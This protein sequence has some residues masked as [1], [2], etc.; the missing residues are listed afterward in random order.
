MNGTEGANQDPQRR[1]TAGR[2]IREGTLRV[3]GLDRRHTKALRD[4]LAPR[5]G[6]HVTVLATVVYLG[7]PD[8]VGFVESV[9]DRLDA[10]WRSMDG[11]ALHARLAEVSGPRHRVVLLLRVRARIL[12]ALARRPEP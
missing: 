4:V 9:L 8:P 2:A 7:V 6:E 1:A 5:D 11:A 10:R 3:T 12:E